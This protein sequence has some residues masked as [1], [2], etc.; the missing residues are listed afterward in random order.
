M[1]STLSDVL[2]VC[3]RALG[4][5]ANNQVV[6][7]K[8]NEVQER[9]LPMGKWVGT[10]QHYRFCAPSGCITLPRQLET[11]ETAA[12]CGG[13]VRIRNEWYEFIG[14]GFGLDPRCTR[15]FQDKG[16]NWISFD[17]VLG[18]NKKLRVYSDTVED[19]N[20][21][22][23]LQ[24]WNENK[25]PVKT[26]VGGR[27][28][29]GEMVTISNAQVNTVN[30]CMAG[31]WVGVQKPI[32]N[33]HVFIYEY[34]TVNLTQRLLAMYEPDE[35]RPNYRRYVI[36]FSNSTS[37][38]TCLSEQVDVIAKLRFI[39]ARNPDDW[40]IIGNRGALKVGCKALHAEDNSAFSESIVYWQLARNILDNELNQFMGDGMEPIIQLTDGVH[41]S[42]V[43][44]LI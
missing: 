20:A 5:C 34:D 37:G 25:L 6:I 36:P 1:R 9:L 31:G 12:V 19:P 22:I 28:I 4:D 27:W 40:M 32:T 8:I 21:K 38:D 11:V 16:E 10:Y 41:D 15:H 17:D 13:P 26:F 42:G 24:F 2:P 30:F 29:D 23:F 35:T 14:N 18:D 44:N 43:C 33:G 3:A 7:D 39:P